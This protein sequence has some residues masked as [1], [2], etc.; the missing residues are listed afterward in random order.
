M[1][2]R[3]LYSL[4][5][6]T[7][8]HTHTHLNNFFKTGQFIDCPDLG[9]PSPPAAAVTPDTAAAADD[10]DTESKIARFSLLRNKPKKKIRKIEF[11]K[12]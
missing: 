12:K 5:Q 3:V 10:S 1:L 11:N 7:H 8:T 6:N 9:P 2:N 4:T